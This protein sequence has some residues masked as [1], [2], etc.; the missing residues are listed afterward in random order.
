M[1]TFYSIFLL[2]SLLAPLSAQES[3]LKP[4][5]TLLPGGGGVVQV[6]T[7][8]KF[9]AGGSILGVSSSPLPA[10]IREQLGLKQGL[11]IDFVVADSAADKAELKAGDILLQ[12]DDQL[13]FS[14]DQLSGLLQFLGVG[15]EVILTYMRQGKRLNNRC[16][17]KQ[18]EG[19]DTTNGDI[20]TEIAEILKRAGFSPDI[21]AGKK[22]DITQAVATV[23]VSGAEMTLRM[24]EGV[25]QAVIMD[26]KGVLI[27]DGPIETEE[28]RVAVPEEYRDSLNLAEKLLP[29]FGNKKT[30]Q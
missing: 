8:D 2:I 11:V 15:K 21:T 5:T 28:Q 1:N 17:L 10:V 23:N 18:A 29:E 20:E 4:E 30:S 13:L 3:K 24:K 27:F 12:I 7:S 16:I 9:I 25:R 26:S 6:G 22:I 19:L 14:T